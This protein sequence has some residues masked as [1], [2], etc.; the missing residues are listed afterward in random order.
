MKRLSSDDDSKR[1]RKSDNH[2]EKLSD[3]LAKREEPMWD[4]NIFQDEALRKAKLEQEQ[5]R[6]RE[7]SLKHLSGIERNTAVL[8]EIS[9]L[10]RTNN[11]KK[12]ELFQL[13]VEML[14][15]LKSNNKEEAVSK[16]RKV[17]DKVNSFKGDVETA[18]SLYSIGNAIIT[19]FNNF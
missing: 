4:L 17:M 15:V 9:Y 8:Q 7:Q 2:L 3:S 19:M 11:E 12:D 5:R 1:L 18:T 10:M 6:Y 13:I 16:Y 14:E